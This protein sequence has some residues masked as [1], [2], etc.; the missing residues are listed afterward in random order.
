MK[1]WKILGLLSTLFILIS[2]NLEDGSNIAKVINATLKYK[3]PTGIINASE[4][5]IPFLQEKS[6]TMSILKDE[7]K[8]I[9]S[10][11]DQNYYFSWFLFSI[12]FI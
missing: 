5:E 4:I 7:D 11:E 8:F 6:E 10:F 1:T 2:F 3:A 12:F 9:F